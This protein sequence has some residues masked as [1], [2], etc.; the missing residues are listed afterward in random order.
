MKKLL[1]EA[2][3]NLI[4]VLIYALEILLFSVG[5][6]GIVFSLFGLTWYLFIELNWA[7]I[8]LSILISGFLLGLCIK[9][10]KIA[11]EISKQR[12]NF[13]KKND[14]SFFTDKD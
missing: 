12:S 9:I 8:I 7:E 10:L 1:N 11:I 4:L 13:A 6:L 5:S 3:I 2:Q 14:N